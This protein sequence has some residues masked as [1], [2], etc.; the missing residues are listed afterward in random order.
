MKSHYEEIFLKTK[1]NCDVIDITSY[2][3]SFIIKSGITEG[4][5]TVFS[6]GSTGGIT[7]IEFEDGLVS[8]IKEFLNNIVP[9][10][11]NYKHN[12]VWQDNNGH[13]HIKS[14]LIKTSLTIPI[15]NKKLTLGTWQQVVF[16]DF[17]IRNRSR[18]ISVQILGD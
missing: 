11:Y 14:S 2:L 1:G 6:V 15:H 4:I 16:I 8:D 18:Q 3:N 12:L 10:E 7:T 5:C 9:E 13:S 17:D